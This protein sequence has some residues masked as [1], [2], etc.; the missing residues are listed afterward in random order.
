MEDLHHVVLKLPVFRPED[1]QEKECTQIRVLWKP[2]GIRR[3]SK[4]MAERLT[5][6]QGGQPNLAKDTGAVFQTAYL[7]SRG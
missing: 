3:T 7:K 2:A 1:T 4:N 6:P 5:W